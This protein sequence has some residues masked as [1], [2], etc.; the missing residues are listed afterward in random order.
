M[1][2]K[3]RKT[4]QKPET[5][6]FGFFGHI[7]LSLSFSLSLFQLE[8]FSNEVEVE[9]CP[10]VHILVAIEMDYNDDDDDDDVDVDNEYYLCLGLF[11]TIKKINSGVT[12]S[13][14]LLCLCVA[15]RNGPNGQNE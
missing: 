15:V 6:P 3:Q 14:I 9:L 2:F 5:R 4:K 13:V 1:M 7:F 10:I 11:W 12:N 8:H